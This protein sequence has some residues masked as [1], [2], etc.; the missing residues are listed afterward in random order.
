MG[1]LV[2]VLV[3]GFDCCGLGFMMVGLWS[4]GCCCFV[5]MTGLDFAC[6]FGV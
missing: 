3:L 4:S 1:V 6:L 2:R 5:L